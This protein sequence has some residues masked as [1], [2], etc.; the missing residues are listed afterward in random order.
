VRRCD[1][2]ADSVLKYGPEKEPR[3]W[4]WGRDKETASDVM[5]MAVPDWNCY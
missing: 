3:K 4:G 1:K 5:P 2:F